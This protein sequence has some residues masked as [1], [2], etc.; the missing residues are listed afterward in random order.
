MIFFH[1]FL[2]IKIMTSVYRF[3]QQFMTTNEILDFSITLDKNPSNAFD[4]ESY[5]SASEEMKERYR[6]NAGYIYDVIQVKLGDKLF[7]QED[8]RKLKIQHIKVIEN[9][10][11]KLDN[12]VDGITIYGKTIPKRQQKNNYYYAYAIAK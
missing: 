8:V 12:F 3:L 7:N 4:E 2:L 5:W 6:S 11:R 9:K 10:S 1:F